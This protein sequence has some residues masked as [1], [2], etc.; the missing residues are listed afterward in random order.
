MHSKCTIS[1]V[2]IPCL[3]FCLSVCPF[4]S[5]K[6]QNQ[7]RTSMIKGGMPPLKKASPPLKKKIDHY[8]LHQNLIYFY[9]QMFYKYT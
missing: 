1:L 8:N 7:A 3:S 2:Y 5:N 9:P 6:R 4:V